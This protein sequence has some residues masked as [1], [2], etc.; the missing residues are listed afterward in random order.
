MNIPRFLRGWPGGDLVI[1]L[2]WIF[3]AIG[4]LWL[5]KETALWIFVGG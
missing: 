2:T 5:V 3:A 1:L 4:L